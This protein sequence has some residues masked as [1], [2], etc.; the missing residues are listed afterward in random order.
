RFTVVAALAAVVDLSIYHLAL[1]GG[2]WEH[3]ARAL[4]FV[5]GTT[6]AYVLN[7]RWSFAVAHTWR[8][9]TGFVALYSTTFVVVLA[10][11]ALALALL[12]MAWWTTTTAW[13]LSQA[14]GRHATSLCCGW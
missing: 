2:V 14:S 9:M 11:H 6:V 10:L 4:S 5:A 12:P 8:R 7:R 13:A 3:A 1:G